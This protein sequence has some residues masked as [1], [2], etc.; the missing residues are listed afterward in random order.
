MIADRS[1]FVNPIFSFF[2]GILLEEQGHWEPRLC[3]SLC[4]REVACGAFYWYINGFTI[5]QDCLAEFARRDYRPFRRMRG[6]ED[7]L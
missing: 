7:A 6:G 4:G 1:Y 2:G 5:C 3:C